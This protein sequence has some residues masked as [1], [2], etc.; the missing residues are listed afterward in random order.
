M[1]DDLLGIVGWIIVGLVIIIGTLAGFQML[2]VSPLWTEPGAAWVQAVGACIGI[3]IAI[4]VPARQNQLQNDREE[5]REKAEIAAT[6]KS[7]KSELQ[8]H[9]ATLETNAGAALRNIRPGQPFR[10]AIRIG[11]KPFVIYNAVAP[12]LGNVPDDGLRN[13]IIEAFAA[14]GS[15]IL[16]I[17]YNNELIDTDAYASGIGKRSNFSHEQQVEKLASEALASYSTNVSTAYKRMNTLI[18]DLLLK[19]P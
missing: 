9:R 5:A 10:V 7:I 8:A 3:G 17:R 19:L 2:S 18:D 14:A 11:E 16:A 6:L 1:R 12:R 4:Y 13:A 15:F